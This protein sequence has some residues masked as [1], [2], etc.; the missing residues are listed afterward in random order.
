MIMVLR[1]L[2]GISI[3]YRYLKKHNR[4]TKF[5]MYVQAV[6]KKTSHQATEIYGV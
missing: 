4:E 3:H 2:K 6:I 5:C 1:S